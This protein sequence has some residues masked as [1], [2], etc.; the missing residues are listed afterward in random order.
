MKSSELISD[1]FMII[2]TSEYKKDRQDSAFYTWDGPEWVATAYFE[3]KALEVWTVG[4]MKILLPNDEGYIRYTDDLI[5]YG[6]TNDEQ[7]QEFSDKYSDSWIHNSWFEIRTTK[8]EW[9]DDGFLAH[10]YHSVEEAVDACLELMQNPE[11]YGV[12]DIDMSHNDDPWN[13]NGNNN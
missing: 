8:G 10:V 2:Y 1:K 11:E 7:L 12:A 9:I 3:D 6:I 5:N 4:E 13:D